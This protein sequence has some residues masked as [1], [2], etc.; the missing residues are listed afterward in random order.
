VYKRQFLSWAERGAVTKMQPGGY[1]FS[2]ECLD[3]FEYFPNL[4]DIDAENFSARQVIIRNHPALQAFG[5][6]EGWGPIGT[7]QI[8]NC[9]A[10]TNIVFYA[11]RIDLLSVS[12][13]PL[14]ALSLEDTMVGSM[15]LDADMTLWGS[16]DERH[17]VSF[18][19]INEDGVLVY[20]ESEYENGESVVKQQTP[21]EFT[22]Q[23]EPQF[24]FSEEYWTECLENSEFGE[25]ELF[26]VQISEKEEA[27]YNEKGQKG[28]A[29]RVFY[30]R[31]NHNYGDKTF[32]I[33]ADEMPVREQFV[34]RPAAING[35]ENVEYSPNRGVCV[36][37]K[38]DLAFVY[39]G[40]GEEQVLGVFDRHEHYCAIAADG[41][42]KA[43][44]VSR[45]R[46]YR[47]SLLRFM[48]TDIKEPTPEPE[49]ETIPIDEAHFTSEVFREF[50]KEEYD[51]DS[52][53]FLSWTERE[54]V[55]EMWLGDSGYSFRRECLDGFEYFPNLTN[56]DISDNC[57]A[58][59]VIIRNHPSLQ[60]FGGSEGGWI[61]TLQIENCPALTKIGFY[62]YRI[63]SLSVSGAPLAVLDLTHTRLDSITLDAD[64][65]LYTSDGRTGEQIY[66]INEDDQFVYLCDS[67]YYAEEEGVCQQT[68]VKFTNQKE[69]QFPFSE[70][71]WTE[72]LENS[73][74]EELELFRVQ[75]SEK[76]EAG[77][78]EKGQKGC[79]VRVFYT[80]SNHDYG[81]KTFVIYADEMPVRDQFVFRPAAINGIEAVEYSPNRG[82]R[83]LTK[84]DL[85][86][87]YRGEEE[88]QV[89][90]V[91]DRHKH[92]CVIAPD[93]AV[94]AV[95]VVR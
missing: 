49:K 44:P 20:Y 84:W 30:T 22:N 3:G 63:D 78:N 15:V 69:P 73:E 65:V 1:N 66:T 56:L 42:V 48:L 39:R 61:R 21:V 51:T 19:R 64:M 10:L 72:C 24:P 34:F 46:E 92:Y 75:I 23:K 77:Y 95:P 60:S 91:F 81:D 33:Y 93:G 45:E 6:S 12:G 53:G 36:F 7:L 47:D 40:E 35:I 2:E 85:A 18:Y 71:Y 32:V 62:I 25:L 83:V 8:E 16:V 58:E 87:V 76:E 5:G 50:I 79:A 29:V 70:E 26:R 38:W 4:T 13:A 67:S 28:Y 68:P 27:G 31:S 94:K 86:F 17:G 89:L 41:A 52:D 9:P 80:R 88:E 11:G 74:F 59:Q 14:A 82:V 54:A 90:D 43:I 55:T 37:T 57:Q